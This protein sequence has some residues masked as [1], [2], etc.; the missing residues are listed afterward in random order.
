LLG[1]RG[2][3]SARWLDGGWGDGVEWEMWDGFWFGLR[4][5]NESEIW[6]CFHSEALEGVSTL[7]GE[8][9]Y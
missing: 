2:G 9:K 3:S 7:H 1:G 6:S 8:S 5:G 4:G